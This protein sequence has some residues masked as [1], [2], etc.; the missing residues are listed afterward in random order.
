[1]RISDCSSDWCSSDLVGS[2]NHYRIDQV[3]ARHFV[4]TAERAGLPKAIVREAIE[5]VRAQAENAVTQME[6]ALPTGSP[7]YIHESV[8]AGVRTRL[9]SLE[10][11]NASCR[12]RVC[13]YG[14]ITVG[15][16]QVKNK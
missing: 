11:G 9:P 12:D 5:E 6:A 2:K 1:M 16:A 14:A 10:T 8:N 13:P 4:Q 3:H 7:H 15:A